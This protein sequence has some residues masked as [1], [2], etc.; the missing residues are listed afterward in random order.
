M[1]YASFEPMQQALCA[2][3]SI[4]E[5]VAAKLQAVFQ[6]KQPHEVPAQ[7]FTAV[8]RATCQLMR[9]QARGSQDADAAWEVALVLLQDVVGSHPRQ[10]VDATRAPGCRPAILRQ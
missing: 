9:E 7:A 3:L 10:P 4:A 1:A 6:G 5:V 8:F 2:P